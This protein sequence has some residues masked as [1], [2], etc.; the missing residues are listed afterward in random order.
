MISTVR[1]E[2]AL[3]DIHVL[4]T[5]IEK[6]GDLRVSLLTISFLVL[7]IMVCILTAASLRY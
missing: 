4:A 6:L 2:I 3:A 7:D 1:L 5:R